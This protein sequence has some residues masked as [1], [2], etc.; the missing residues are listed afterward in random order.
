M[1]WISVGSD[2]HSASNAPPQAATACEACLIA[3][4]HATKREF[5]AV[6]GIGDA[7]AQAL[8]DAQPLEAAVCAI[9]E[10]EAVLDHVSGIGEM[11]SERI[12]RYFCPELY[13]D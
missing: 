11:L 12:A 2:V 8:V 3:L 13:G 9:R 4:N 6:P 7:K 1:L 5:D 10:I